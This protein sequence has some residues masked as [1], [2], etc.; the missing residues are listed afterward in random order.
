MECEGLLRI[1][2][3]WPNSS[4]RCEQIL[5]NL[6][7]SP[8]VTWGGQANGMMSGEWKKH[9]RDEKSIQKCVQETWGEN[10]IWASN[11]WDAPRSACGS[12]FMWIIRHASTQSFH[13]AGVR[14]AASK[15]LPLASCRL[16]AWL[17]HRQCRRKLYVLPTYQWNSTR[18]DG[19]TIQTTVFIT[20]LSR[21]RF[22]NLMNT[23]HFHPPLTNKQPVDLLV[24]F[25]PMV[26]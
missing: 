6:H 26:Q 2:V 5:H 24:T 19:V 21:Y 18:L 14:H 7:Y 10:T 23:W 3:P 9:R 20:A 16:P 25:P 1:K 11:A 15:A 4:Q 22:I 13:A 8:N 12:V 17:T